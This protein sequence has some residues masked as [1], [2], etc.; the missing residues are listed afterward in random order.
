MPSHPLPPLHG[1]VSPL[2]IGGAIVALLLELIFAASYIGAL[3]RPQPHDVPYGVVAPP[4][5]APTVL[6][7]LRTGGG[8]AFKVTGE[9]SAAALMRAIDQRSLYGGLV[10]TP[11]G[12][13]LI[14]ADAASLTAA[15]ALTAFAQGVATAQNVPLSVRHTY[16]LPSGDTRG[17]SAVYLV[18]AWVFGGYLCGTILS[19]LRGY[20]YVS[21]RHALLRI[22]LLAGYAVLSGIFGAAIAEPLTG[23]LAGDFVQLATIGTLLVFA[24][25]AATMAIQLLL[26]IAGTLVAMIAFVLLGNPSSG[27]VFPPEFLPGFWRAIGPWL[28][29]AAGFTLVRNTLYF[30]GVAVGG[31][32][33]VLTV[34]ALA[35]VALLL[36][37]AN[38]RRSSSPVGGEAEIATAAAAGA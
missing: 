38:R 23:A 31:A 37:F 10:F 34:Y 12:L 16:L 26:G 29:N 11:R 36:A 9:D 27:G 22:L 28:P 4:A 1:V 21:R 25:T 7:Q 5:I 30:G 18:F 35:G 32:I 19:T 33:L 14:V 17:L 24:V 20:T 3:H 15:Q 2:A 13:Q 8:S 6:R